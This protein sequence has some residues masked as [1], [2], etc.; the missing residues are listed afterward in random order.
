MFFWIVIACYR[1]PS[2]LHL[3]IFI[4]LGSMNH[5]KQWVQDSWYLVSQ[6]SHQVWGHIPSDQFLL[7]DQS[8]INFHQQSAKLHMW[9]IIRTLTWPVFNWLQIEWQLLWMHQENT[10]LQKFHILKIRTPQLISWVFI[11]PERVNLYLYLEFVDSSQSFL[12]NY[13]QPPSLQCK[14]APLHWNY[15]LYEFKVFQ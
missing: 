14:Y 5:I 12:G 10:L 9:I 11:L 7:P 4:K 8:W 2:L 1:S 13:T 3:S 15:A 6:I